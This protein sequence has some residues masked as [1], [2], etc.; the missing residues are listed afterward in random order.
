MKLECIVPD[1]MA[2]NCYILKDGKGNAALFDPG[3]E[4]MDILD[5]VKGLNLEYIILTHGHYDHILGVD[6]VKKAHPEAR[7]VFPASEMKC[8]EDGK[9][10]LT[11]YQGMKQPSFR[12]DILVRDGDT[13]DFSG[14]EFLVISTPGHTEGGTCYYL[15][16]EGL[17]FSGDTLF[18]L[19]YGRTDFPG[20]N[21]NELIRSL[22]R[23]C[24]LPG[25]TKV[26]PGHGPSTTIDFEKRN[27]SLMRLTLC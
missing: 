11:A 19:G 9:Y 5:S 13:F 6:A 10:S 7:I 18:R 2:A 1:G 26:Y 24:K 12:P 16:K 3:A 15:K 25:D 23:L 17:L 4:S 14:E 27:N 21:E 20:G 22:S 8:L